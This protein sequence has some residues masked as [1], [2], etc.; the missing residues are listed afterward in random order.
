MEVETWRLPA[1]GA[2]ELSALVGV[3]F[4]LVVV[5]RLSK[6]LVVVIVNMRFR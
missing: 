2:V 3:C 5:L 4:I 6:R 1:Y